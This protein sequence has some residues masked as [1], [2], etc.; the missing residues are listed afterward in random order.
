KFI[1]LLGAYRRKIATTLIGLRPPGLERPVEKSGRQPLGRDL[2]DP[3]GRPG[4]P[5]EV[6]D[7]DRAPDCGHAGDEEGQARPADVDEPARDEAA[8]GPRSREGEEV[9]PDH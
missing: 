8:E 7:Q 9:E 1:V 5:E 6:S 4:D 3:H 2:L